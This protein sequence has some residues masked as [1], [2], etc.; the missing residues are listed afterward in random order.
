MVVS[1]ITLNLFN[2]SSVSLNDNFVELQRSLD[3][4]RLL[5]YP[6]QLFNSTALGFNATKN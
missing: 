5:V 3:R 2:D 6:F 4:A 1:L